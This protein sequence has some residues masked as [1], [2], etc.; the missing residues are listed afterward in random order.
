MSLLKSNG[1]YYGQVSSAALPF[2]TNHTQSSGM[3]WSQHNGALLVLEIN[4]TGN[5]GVKMAPMMVQVCAHVSVIDGLT[6][7]K[8]IL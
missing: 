6:S 8:S 7:G 5:S 4:V 1:G 3:K 2:K